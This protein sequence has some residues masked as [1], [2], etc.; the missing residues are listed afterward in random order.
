MKKYSIIIITADR[1]SVLKNCLDRLFEFKVNEKADII[2]VDASANVFNYEKINQI[3]YIK[4]NSK[5]RGF[6]NQRNIG[7][8]NALSDYII[9]IDDDVE[10]TET[11]FENFVSEFENYKDK[12]F[13]AMGA[14][15]PKKNNVISFVCG[16]LGHPGGGFRL[17][18]LSKGEVIFLNQ[19]A[20]CNTIFNK[21]IIEEVGYFDVENKFGSED[22]EL[23]LRVFRNYG[24]EK[25]IFIPDAVVW[26]Y[27]PDTIFKFV[28]WYIRR[29]IADI[30]IYLRHILHLNYV[31]KTL[32][33]IKIMFVFFISL[34][35]GIRFLFFIWFLYYFW[36]LYRYKFMIKYFKF[37]KFSIFKRA[38][39]IF[40]FPILKLT[41]DLSFDIGRIKRVIEKKP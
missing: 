31:L 32:V 17:H 6:S 8:R 12:V 28:K 26:H 10:I 30:D 5:S 14:T 27:S 23:C 33:T 25:F 38:L 21:K 18:N 41:A 37:Y 40:G 39:I 15:F 11:W 35:L 13:G 1:H 3:K 19:V 4:I 2:V 20:T 7:V 9:F 29:G 36:Q 16:V 22:S 34:F 24:K